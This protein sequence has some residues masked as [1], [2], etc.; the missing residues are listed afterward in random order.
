MGRAIAY[1]RVST[2]EQGESGAGLRA[3]EDA[4]RGHAAWLG[5]EVVGPF[6]DPGISGAA[7]L[8]ARP[9]AATWAAIIPPSALDRE[10]RP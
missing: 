6:A 4:C 2:D 9:P 1:L 10:S 8:D 5:S 7:P 3:Q